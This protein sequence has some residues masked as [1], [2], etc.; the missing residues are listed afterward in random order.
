MSSINNDNQRI[1]IHADLN[2][3][4][5]TAEQQANPALRDKPVGVVKGRG[6][7]CI[8]A[9]SIEAKRRGVMT[10]ARVSDAKRLCPEIILIPADF[11]KYEYISRRFIKICASYSPACEVFSIDE[12]FLDVTETEHLF[13]NVFNIAFDLKQRLS[14]E[15]GDYMTCSVGISHNK[16]LAKLASNQIKP[17]GLFWITDDNAISILDRSK[18]MDVCGLGFGLFRHLEKLGIDSSLKLRACSAEF[19][20][21]HFGPHWSLHLYNICRGIDNLP[22][23]P[24]NDI[25]DAKSVGRTYT[26]HRLLTRRDEMEKVMRNLCE[27]AAGKARQM[28]LVGRYVSVCLREGRGGQS[29]WGH[30]TLYDYIDS[31]KVFFD[32]CRKI[33]ADWLVRDAIF[34]G[35]TL[36]ML[37]PKKYQP[38]PLFADDRRNERLVKSMDLANQKYGDYTVF[39]AQLLSMPIVMPEV[40]GYFGDRKY[41]LSKMEHL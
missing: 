39:P 41:Q 12:C 23:I 17:D 1:I 2:S 9:A 27:E 10:G 32:L 3:F 5:A 36:A 25:A 37:A 7:T 11:T 6:R 38:I 28:G 13:G 26:T 20:Y 33:S 24:I 15:I 35:V 18:L 16:F 21:K 40:T 19:L 34:C 29:Y 31:G 8:I 14:R 4:F 30:L 22:V